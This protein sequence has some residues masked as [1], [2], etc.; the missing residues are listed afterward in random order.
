MAAISAVETWSL[1]KL[2]HANKA[3]VVAAAVEDMAAAAVVAVDMAAVVV[4]AVEATVAAAAVVAAGAVTFAVTRATTK[5]GST[6]NSDCL[7]R[8]TRSP[9][10]FYREP[11]PGTASPHTAAR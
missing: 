7:T 9:F 11:K 3:V 2:A 4:V 10:L 1:M 8:G 5:P 6:L